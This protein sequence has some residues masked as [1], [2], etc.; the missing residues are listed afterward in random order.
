MR[1]HVC[2][3]SCAAPARKQTL[4]RFLQ[5]HRQL[6]T[7]QTPHT[8]APHCIVHQPFLLRPTLHCTLLH[9]HPLNLPPSSPLPSIPPRS[10]SPYH[11]PP[12]DHIAPALHHTPVHPTPPCP[13][14]T[15]PRVTRSTTLIGWSILTVFALSVTMRKRADKSDDV[16]ELPP[17]GSDEGDKQMGVGSWFAPPCAQHPILSGD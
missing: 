1:I 5:I 7:S 17:R 16:L 8:T 9:S 11:T 12:L 6:F 2:S 4:G 14:A 15:S 10:I 13:L 3:W